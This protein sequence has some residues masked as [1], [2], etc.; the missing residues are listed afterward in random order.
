VQ[1]VPDDPDVHAFQIPDRAGKSFV[2]FRMADRIAPMEYEVLLDDTPAVFSLAGHRGAFFFFSPSG[3]VLAYE[4]SGDLWIGGDQWLR[5]SD[6]LMIRSL[7]WRPI[8]MSTHLVILP[9][10]QGTLE[11]RSRAL[12]QPVVVVGEFR[13]RVWRTYETFEPFISAGVLSIPIDAD[14]AT[15]ILM[16]CEKGGESR[17]GLVLQRRLRL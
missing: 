2:F 12:K 5:S 15:C 7:D 1:I 13:D 16:V 10:E 17:A 9:V 4:G 3:E 14:R 11:L 8:P 6:S